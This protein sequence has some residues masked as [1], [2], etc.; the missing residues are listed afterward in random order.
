MEI[1]TTKVALN[2]GL[3]LP[4][5]GCGPASPVGWDKVNYFGNSS[6]GRKANKW[7]TKIRNGRRRAAWVDRLA[8]QL[9]VGYRLIDFSISYGDISNVRK[10]IQKSGVPRDEVFVASR[11]SNTNQYKGKLYEVFKSTKQRLGNEPIDLFGF[12]WPVT[13]HYIQTYKLL[14]QLYRDGEIRAIAICNCNQHHLE[15]ILD[16][17][18]I[19]PAI[20]QFEV[21]P[22]M[23]Q[24]PLIEFC[25][26]N[27][28]QVEAY[29]PLARNDERL[30]KASVLTD[31][32]K[33]YNKTLAQIILRWH[34]QLGLIPIPLSTNDE[35]LRQ[36]ISIF[37]F[38]LTDDEVA[39]IDAVNINSRLR[40]DPDN[41][42]FSK[43]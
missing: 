5:V 25:K 40:Y 11:F 28:I 22:L 32:A 1:L 34:I 14:E 3:Y 21:H 18:D 42:D 7:L 33:K 43:L 23:T 8:Y 41:C 13:G 19:V 35:R 16:E 31:A 9:K 12:H 24:K 39:A 30:Y 17:C 10:A 6:V 29:T 37:D 20:N 38:V 27:N 2:N 4:F 36:N 26:Q 15:R